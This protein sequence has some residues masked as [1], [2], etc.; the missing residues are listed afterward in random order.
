MST[1]SVRTCL[2]FQDRADEAARLYTSLIP[3]SRIEHLFPNRADPTQTFLV[4]LTLA[5]QRFS[6]LNGGLHYSLTPAA[7]IELHLDTQAEVDRLWE[8]LLD[9]GTPMRCGWLTDRFGVSWQIVPRVLIDL[10]QTPDDDVAQRVT[11]AM[12]QMVRLDG[13]ALVAAARG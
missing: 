6:F 7:S 13:P 11:R 10:M 2:W 9:G 3:G 12:A 1:L 8:A 5:G 4:H